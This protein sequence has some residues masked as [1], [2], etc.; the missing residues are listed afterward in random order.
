MT[1]F[2]LWHIH[3]LKDDFG[4]HE[5]EK[6]I[7]VFSSEEKA[8]AAIELLKYREGFRDYP[9]NCFE[10]H[11]TEVDQISWLDG[12]SAVYWCE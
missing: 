11:E 12:F 2:L 10:I 7:G 4:T 6:L 3:D 1:V 8:N 5:E 9:L